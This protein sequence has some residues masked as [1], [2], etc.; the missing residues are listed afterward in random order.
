MKL[1]TLL[2]EALKPSQYR[3][4]VK[5]WDKN[6]YAQIF[7]KYPHDRNAYRI[8]LPLPPTTPTSKIEPLIQQK[9]ATKNY[10]IS[11]Y[12]SGMA[13]DGRRQMRIGKLLSDDPQLTK[14]FANDPARSATKQDLMVV[15]SRHPYDIAGMSTGRGWTSCMNLHDGEN[16][17]YVP[18]EIEGGTLI[19]YLVNVNDK[20]IEKPLAR[21]LIK[22]FIN[23]I[24]PTDIAFGIENKVY[25]T[26]TASFVDV[27]SRWVNDVNNARA[28]N[29]IFQFNPK[30]YRDVYG[31]DFRTVIT[32][33]KHDTD[34]TQIDQIIADPDN[35]QYIKDPSYELQM[36]AV[37]QEGQ[38]IRFI[39]DPSY[40]LQLA[41]VNQN[42]NAIQYIKDP[43]EEVQLA[44]VN[45]NGRAL[46]YIKYPSYELQLAAVNQNGNAIQYIKDPSEEVQLAAV[47]QYGRA[48][49][50]IKDPSEELQLAAVN[51]NG[52][53]IQ[54]IK[55]P[56]EELQLAAVNQNAYVIK[57]IKDPSYELQL[58]AIKQDAFVIQYIKDPSY[59]LQLAAIKQNAHAI[60][61]IK[62]PSYELQLAAVNQNGNAIRHF[63]YPS[64]ELQLAAVNQNGNAIQYIKDPSE[65]VQLAAVNQNGNAIQHI[66]NPTRKVI[67]VANSNKTESLNSSFKKFLFESL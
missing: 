37:K 53:A 66:K 4:L 10:K 33:G 52:N 3:N 36:T 49:Q 28:L 12:V 57:Y 23:V 6:R 41:A 59:E 42:G 13:T 26:G 27:V 35:I 38:V 17:H 9:L 11:D 40:E 48:L 46:Q 1:S 15:I 19:A 34:Q 54:Y 21:T 67:D 20:N 63:K 8:Y 29:G 39:K 43:S 31:D 5:S 56:S 2:A 7:S 18:A 60:Q 14:Q 44:A 61:Y 47:T 51:Q 45:Q 25:G 55:D 22:P 50:Y 58:A 32:L 30:S 65:E 62:D 16:A 64:E 24:N